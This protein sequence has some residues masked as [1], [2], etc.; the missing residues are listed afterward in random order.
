MINDS[1]PILMIYGSDAVLIRSIHLPTD[2]EHP[3]HAVETSIGNFIILH[4][5][6]EKAE[7]WSSVRAHEMSYW[8]VSEVTRDGQ[9]VIQRFIPAHEAQKLNYPRYI[10]LDSDDRVFVAGRWNE[11]V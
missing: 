9:E 5:W 11:R 4:L 2:I 3:V 8:V 1:S 7:H 6:E 10:S